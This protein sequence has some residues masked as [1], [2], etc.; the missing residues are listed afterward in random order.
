MKL[1][2]G[3]S[4][5]FLKGWIN[6][7]ILPPEGTT[8]TTAIIAGNPLMI[9]GCE[10][11][12]REVTAL[13]CDDNTVD[14]IYCSH[15]LDHLSRMKEVDRALSEW[16]RI[17]KPRGILRVAVSDFEKVVKMYNEGLALERLLGHIVGGHK[18]DFDHHGIVFDFK[19]LRQYLEKHGFV[20]VKRY[21]WQDFLPKDF[22][23]LSACYIPHMDK[24]NGI[25][26]SLNVVCT[27]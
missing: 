20:D 26:M 22:D 8:L 18:T 6:C 13:D 16:Y 17:L 15:V 7:D 10:F 12:L 21:R 27:K 1:H 24:E 3:C 19:L 4:N 11:R 14:E 23:D 9:D 2:L 5:R 25:L